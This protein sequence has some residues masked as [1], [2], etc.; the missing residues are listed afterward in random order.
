MTDHAKHDDHAHDD[1]MGHPLPAWL[2]LA[3]FGALIVF[4][5]LTVSVTK[6]D[7]GGQGNFIVAMIIATIKAGLVMAYFM[8]LRWDNRLNVLIFLSSFLF[9]SLFLTMALTDRQE[10]QK[11]IDNFEQT[12]AAEAAAAE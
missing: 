6:F 12:K 4:T 7:L 2:L 1:G 5:V 11:L 10:Y 3:V 9:V 8:H